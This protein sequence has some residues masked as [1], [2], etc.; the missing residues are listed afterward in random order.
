MR[1]FWGAACA[2]L[3][4]AAPVAA[5]RFEVTAIGTLRQSPAPNQ[6]LNGLPFGEGSFILGRWTV[7]IAAGTPVAQTPPGMPTTGQAR[8]IPGAV[9][10]GFV[11]IQ[12][13]SGNIDFNQTGDSLG[14][15]Y[16]LDNVAGGPGRLLD[17][18]TLTD[19]TR[20]TPGGLVYGLANNSGG[21]LPPGVF[22][23]SVSFGRSAGGPLDA[24]PTLLTSFDNLDPFTLWQAGPVLFGLNFRSGT[25]TTVAEYLALPVRS[26][27]VNTL[28]V[29]FQEISAVPEP[30]S[31]AMLII[32]FGLTGAALRRRRTSESCG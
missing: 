5:K 17:Q 11:S 15:L 32:G 20:A 26:F 13:T 14:A 23:G 30:G 22:L 27:S 25:A 4:L 16:A 1:I 10:N 28:G 18:L 6:T 19:G 9:K 3:M 31:W 24:P 12:S 2:A 21:F 8:L 29:N 7:D